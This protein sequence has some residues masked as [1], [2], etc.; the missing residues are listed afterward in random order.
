MLDMT[1]ARSRKR[2]KIRPQ[3]QLMTSRKSS[4]YTRAPAVA[5]DVCIPRIGPGSWGQYTPRSTLATISCL[6]P[7]ILHR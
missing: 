4:P 1:K 3:V 2:C 5:M 7:D 6:V